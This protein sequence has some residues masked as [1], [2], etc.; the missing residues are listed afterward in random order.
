MLCDVLQR[1]TDT[2]RSRRLSY[3][4][5]CKREKAVIHIPSEEK[6]ANHEKESRFAVDSGR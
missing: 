6:S 1:G 5:K 4:P 2:A 3:V